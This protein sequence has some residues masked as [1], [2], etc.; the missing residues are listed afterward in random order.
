MLRNLKHIL[1]TLVFITSMLYINAQDH[2]NISI[3]IEFDAAPTNAVASITPLRYNKDFAL[4]FTIDD[5]EE[6]VYTYA[7]PLLNGGTLN[8]DVYQ[9]LFF[10]D[11][12]GND[13]NFSMTAAIFSMIG[14]RDVHEEGTDYADMFITWAEIED[15]YNNGW[16][17]ANHGFSSSVAGDVDYLVA[18]N[19]SYIRSHTNLSI[20]NGV[21]TTIFVNP[22]G[23]DAFTEPA[24]NQGYNAAYRQFS[25]GV[26]YLNVNQTSN[27]IDLNQLKM[28]RSEMSGATSIANLADELYGASQTSNVT[29]W[30]ATFNH[31]VAGGAGYSFSAFKTYMQHIAD[32][33][34][35]DGLDNIWFASEEF[36]LDYLLVKDAI[37]LEQSLNGNV[38][39]LTFSGDLPIDL[40]N[41]ALSLLV[42]VENERSITNITVNGASNSSFSSLNTDQALINFEWNG[43]N[44]PSVLETA[45]FYVDSA[46]SALSENAAIIAY[47][48]V[49]MLDEGIEK[50]TLTTRLSNLEGIIIPDLPVDCSFSLGND[51]TIC[52]GSLIRLSGPAGKDSY[53]WN[54]GQSTQIIETTPQSATT[55]ILTVTDDDCTSKD[56]IV[57]SISTPPAIEIISDTSICP[58]D[59]VELWATGGSIYSWSTG[60]ETST[61]EVCPD[62]PTKYVVSVSNDG[63]CYTKDSVIVT[64]RTPPTANAGDDVTLNIGECTT[65]NA[66]GGVEY[67]WNTGAITNSIEV[68]PTNTTDYILTAYDQ[69]GCSDKDTVSIFMSKQQKV[70]NNSGL[71]SIV[72]NFASAPGSYSVDKSALKYNKDFALSLHLDQAKKDAY[73]HAFKM[74]NGGTIDGTSYPG[75]FFTDGCGNNMNFTLS[76]S[77]NAFAADGETDVHDPENSTYNTEYSSWSDLIEMYKA[78]WSLTNIGLLPDNSGNALYSVNRNHSYSKLQTFG[79]IENGISFKALVAPNNDSTFN[80]AALDLDYKLILNENYNLGV[81]RIN[82]EDIDVAHLDSLRLGRNSLNNRESLAKLADS[83]HSNSGQNQHPWASAFLNSVTDG[84]NEGY[85]FSVFELYM[86]YIEDTYGKDGL[87]NIWVASEEEIQN[88]LKVY[89]LINIH[90]ELLD[91]RLLITFSGNAPTDLRHYALSLIV[92]SDVAIE[93]IIING[94][95][96]STS[97]IN[98]DNTALI[99]LNWIGQVDENIFE[100]TEAAVTKTEMDQ[101][102]ES[103]LIALDYINMLD[104]GIE[105]SSFIAR[106]SEIENVTLPEGYTNCGFKLGNDTALCLGN[107]ITLSI[108]DRF[109]YLWSTGASTQEITIT[110]TSD[111]TIFA[112]AENALGCLSHDTINILVFEIPTIA[113][114]NDTLICPGDSIT[115]TASGGSK[116]LW[117]TGD[118]TA[119]IKVS[120]TES[121]FYHVDVF[122]ASGCE[123][124]DSVYVELFAVNGNAGI[125]VSICKGDQTFLTATGGYG[126]VWSTGDN[127]NTIQVSPLDTTAYTVEVLNLNGCYAKDTVVVN[128]RELPIVDAGQDVLS[129]RG[130]TVQLTASGGL[131]YDWDHGPDTSA[132]EVNPSIETQYFVSVRDQFGCS[133]RDSVTVSI[134]ESIDLQ[135]SGLSSAYCE[136]ASASLIEGI[137]AGGVFEGPGVTGNI[138]SPTAAGTGIHK[139]TYGVENDGC[140]LVDTFLVSINEKP[141]ILL[142][143][144]T[145]A[146]ADETIT[147][148]A[149]GGYDSYLWSNGS[150]SPTHFQDSTGVG[151]G[152]LTLDLIVTNNGCVSMTSIDVTFISCFTGIEDLESSGISIYPN[153]S[154]GELNINLNGRNEDLTVRIFNMHGQEV[155]AKEII[156]CGL[157]NCKEK[158]NLHHLEKGMYVIQFIADDFFS[159]GKLFIN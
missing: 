85:A 10:T 159:T 65:L 73:T 104:P 112:Q 48:Y 132:I 139:I 135:V 108:P 50:S 96:V 138:F 99:N 142:P 146:C 133:S 101:T 119:S 91:D 38:L 36:V 152:T 123:S 92:E 43:Q 136:G 153:P 109:E 86:N 68:C 141:R 79:E 7:F 40:R 37:T 147:L 84:L 80:R 19:H 64:Q 77:I 67:L 106:L 44:M 49:S 6:E 59:C 12:C 42:D 75:L 72:I 89:D 82:V 47:D 1:L 143:A 53:S 21:Y 57:V 81:P 94:G 76:T 27:I 122:N 125:D 150:T 70:S 131:F 52:A 130:A 140:Y 93:S 90:E 115:L 28:G 51:T 102:T 126:Y 45:T 16:S 66:S 61:I 46:E 62:V 9:G 20:P 111:T 35:K 114:T 31:S 158:L 34:G 103:A 154:N 100:L 113:I 128:V 98:N 63:G 15:L 71:E 13:I 56:T 83:L 110:P 124:R 26:D 41:Y 33:Y 157:E 4:S 69:V 88:Y 58:G 116:F 87:D 25:Y 149:G 55:F 105:R 120:P 145:S 39:T 97:K 54:T 8:N 17:I 22:N 14:T 24:F 5:G 155:F 95:S 2:T 60:E 129:C 117:E 151:F 78:G 11:G 121:T 118:T 18:R 29:P 107:N 127:T 32:T 3:N 148:N 156:P 134:K 74:L 23:Q 137:P 30:A 144:D